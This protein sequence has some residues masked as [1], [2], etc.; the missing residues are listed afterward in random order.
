VINVSKIKK[1]ETEYL[2]DR[3]GVDHVADALTEWMQN[4]GMKR[5]DRILPFFVQA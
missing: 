5:P 2:L 4:T 3:A 1:A